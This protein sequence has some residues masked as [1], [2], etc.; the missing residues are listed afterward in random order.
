[1]VTVD[2]CLFT[3]IIR[4]FPFLGFIFFFFPGGGDNC[5]F[6]LITLQTKLAFLVTVQ[7]SF[8]NYFVAMVMCKLYV[9]TIQFLVLL[10]KL[11]VTFYFG[12]LFAGFRCSS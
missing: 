1:M 4:K 6:T 12:I 9:V 5:L 3:L 2:N 8:A 10:L 11:S 7:Y